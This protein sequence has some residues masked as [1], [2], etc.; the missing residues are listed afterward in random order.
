MKNNMDSKNSNNY[1]NTPDLNIEL[2]GERL[3]TPMIMASG[4]F[5]YGDEYDFI[6]MNPVAGFVTKGLSI[7]PK[8]GNTTPRIIETASGII[9]SVGLQNVGIKEFISNKIPEISKSLKNTK[10]IANF[11]GNYDEEYLQAAELLDRVPELFAL[12]MNI[13]CPNV[14]KGGLA[15]GQDPKMVEKLTSEVKKRIKKPL[16][17]KLTPNVTDIAG[18]A[19]AAED[20]G[21]DAVSLI[22]TIKA[23]KIDIKTGKP[24]LGN[25]MGGLSGRAIKPVAIRAVYEV[26]K[27]VKIPIIG[28][29]GI[30]TAED[31]IEF[32]MAGAT[33][34]QIGSAVF[35]DPNICEK[36][37][38]DLIRFCQDNKINKLSDIKA[39]ALN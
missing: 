18:I 29:G 33:C 6:N 8:E 28:M 25:C 37:N 3:K 31:L 15:C 10:M 21:A 17:V 22:N 36:I 39:K 16:I 26:A 32:M 23:I 11:F 19:K 9:N 24:M 13:S 1:K 27:V 20:A 14:K 12:E 34:V 7:N 2:F 4:V 38:D 35:Y 30:F 5:G